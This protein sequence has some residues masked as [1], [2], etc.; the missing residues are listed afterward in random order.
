M[1][2]YQL[3]NRMTPDGFAKNVNEYQAIEE[4]YAP[5]RIPPGECACSLADEI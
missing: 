2:Y 4:I 5:E 3:P 1:I